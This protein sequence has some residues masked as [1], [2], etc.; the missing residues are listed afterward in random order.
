MRGA[1]NAGE[2]SKQLGV[3]AI[4]PPRNRSGVRRDLAI[5]IMARHP[6]RVNIANAVNCGVV[7]SD[8]AARG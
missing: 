8:C 7:D 2:V 3:T 5:A 4:R 1:L 6:P